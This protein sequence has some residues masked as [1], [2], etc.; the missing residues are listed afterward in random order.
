MSSIAEQ[1]YKIK[2]QLLKN[3]DAVSSFIADG[4]DN[5]ASAHEIE[6]GL[7]KEMM[8]FGHQAFQVFFNQCG[9]G[10]EGDTLALDDG[11]TLKRLATLHVRP[12]LTVF[13]EYSLPRFVY[14][15]REGQ[16]I[17]HVPLDARLQLPEHKFSYL[18]QDWNQRLSTEL[19]FGKVND[20]LSRIVGFQ[21]SV[22][23]LEQSGRRLSEAAEGFWEQAEQPE[24]QQEGELM[25]VTA[26]GKGVVMRSGELAENTAKRS[27]ASGRRGNKKMA[28]IG[29]AYTVDPFPR[30]PDQIMAALFSDLRLVDDDSLA[31]RPKP[32]YKRVRGALLRN[33]H[34]KTDP[35]S[36]AIFSWLSEE[37]K[38]RGLP[39]Q[40]TLVLIMDGQESLW[41]S[42]V[43]HLPENT[44]RVIEILDLIHATEYVWKATHLFYPKKRSQANFHAREQIRRLLNNQVNSVMADWREKAKQENF[45]AADNEALEKIC[46]Y[47]TNHAHRMRYKDYLAQGL[48]V[49]SGVIEGA[50]RNVVKDRMEHSGMRWTMKGAHAM[51][52]LRSIRLSGL[53]DEF[54]QY[55]RKEE[56]LRRYSGM[57]AANDERFV[58]VRLA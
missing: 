54:M 8:R 55:W 39:K 38:Q 26:D 3:L 50:C 36:E 29:A 47:F 11:R 51:L 2:Q 34:D 45:S 30:S 9:S 14:G 56:G 15:S 53:W 31:T 43:E 48:P 37:V 25:V 12:Y 32:M 4:I 52:G 17:E 1:K 24:A 58:T 6:E 40:K 23:S 10:D 44:F 28:L 21:Q 35:Q 5:A 20:S 13:G 19:P 33:E 41:N 46:G 18:L 16:K 57:N 7:W 22:D 49:A 27:T 42:G